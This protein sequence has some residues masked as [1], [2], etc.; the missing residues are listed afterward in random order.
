[1]LMSH[2]NHRKTR[3]FQIVSSHEISSSVVS[4]RTEMRTPVYSVMYILSVSNTAPVFYLKLPEE[5][6]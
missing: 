2:V 3:C 4:V 5:N 1:M 6:M